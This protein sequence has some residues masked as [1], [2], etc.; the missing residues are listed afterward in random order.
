MIDITDVTIIILPAV[1]D[2]LAFITL[3]VALL[4]DLLLRLDL[5]DSHD[6]AIA[7]QTGH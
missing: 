1:E 4:V 7:I 2:P 5:L 6:L 3:L